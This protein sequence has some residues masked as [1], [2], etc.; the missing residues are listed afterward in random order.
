MMKAKKKPKPPEI[1][2][3]KPKPREVK[4]PEGAVEWAASD[5][6]FP[7]ELAEAIIRAPDAHRIKAVKAITSTPRAIER[8]REWILSGADS[9]TLHYCL[10]QWIVDPTDD[11]L[12]AGMASESALV[13]A[14]YVATRTASASMA[15]MLYAMADDDWLVRAEVPKNELFD[16]TP[17]MYTA[18]IGDPCS[19]VRLNWNQRI[20]EELEQ[21]EIEMTADYVSST[22]AAKYLRRSRSTIA[23]YVREGRLVG[24]RTGETGRYRISME[25][26]DRMLRVEAADGAARLDARREAMEPNVQ[27]AARAD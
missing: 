24:H 19:A 4:L 16:P 15:A 6:A 1:P 2:A 13:R 22:T 5:R 14:S 3:A 8:C 9:F 12:R 7:T 17:A 18:G 10:R 26:I 20:A 27:E 21:Q 23:R 25:S 11:E